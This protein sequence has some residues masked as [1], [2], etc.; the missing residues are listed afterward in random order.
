M[1]KLI[2]LLVYLLCFEVYGQNST[3][4][5]DSTK[6]TKPVGTSLISKS[7]FKK[8]YEKDFSGLI[9]QDGL[10]INQV[11]VGVT[12]PKIEISTLFKLCTLKGFQI[13]WLSINPYFNGNLDSDGYLSIFKGDKVNS[14]LSY[15]G[16]IVL[17]PFGIPYG[18]YSPTGY[19][20]DTS[21]GNKLER[22]RLNTLTIDEEI[23]D[24]KKKLE[25]YGEIWNSSK[26]EKMKYMELDEKCR[27][28]EIIRDNPKKRENYENEKLFNVEKDAKWNNKNYVFL[29]LDF[30]RGVKSARLFKDN[31][32]TS[33]LLNNYSVNGTP[34]FNFTHI[35]MKRG[36]TFNF[37]AN[38][39]KLKTNSIF[40]STPKEFIE[41]KPINGN[42]TLSSIETKETAY[43][44]T[45]TKVKKER[46]FKRTSKLGMTFYFEKFKNSGV[47]TEWE[48]NYTD[49]LWNTKFALLLP[50]I[51]K[52][53]STVT[54]AN[55]QIILS[56]KDL[57]NQSELN[58]INNPSFKQKALVY[59]QLGLPL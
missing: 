49:N 55:F 34:S 20:F 54:Q 48:R 28:L 41:S 17:N 44:L 40:D 52:E 42:T 6:N 11:I 36:F 2:F 32:F 59:I 27:A 26:E 3:T 50:N 21:E 15:G 7:S 46:T 38:Y 43:D 29:S 1:K 39:D 35:N 10:P 22:R 24:L 25:A 18:K 47:H 23:T 53:G 16:R 4:K 56:I 8:L 33:E 31:A 37:Y 57:Y 19:F 58:K 30:N 45:D 51:K 9:G 14:E 5:N 12:K 13:P